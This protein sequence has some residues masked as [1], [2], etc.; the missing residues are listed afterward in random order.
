M[1]ITKAYL[2]AA[3]E[4]L[5]LLTNQPVEYSTVIDGKRTT[6]I[7]HYH[8][9]QAYGGNQLHQTTNVGGGVRTISRAGYDTKKGLYNEIQSLMN[10]IIIAQDNG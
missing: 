6:N 2:D 1:K 9:S 8:I 3:V 4:S 10:G 5:N 7:G